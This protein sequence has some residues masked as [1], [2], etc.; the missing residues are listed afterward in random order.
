MSTQEIAE[1]VM[2]LPEKERL[3]LARRIVTSIESEDVS[4]RVADAV[5][6]IED[7]VTGKVAGLNESEFRDALK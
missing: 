1:A 4:I 3:E 2:A 5:R 7:V 6:G